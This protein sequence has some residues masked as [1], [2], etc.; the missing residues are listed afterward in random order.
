[1]TSSNAVQVAINIVDGIG[2]KGYWEIYYFS[3]TDPSPIFNA[4]VSGGASGVL[5]SRL[6]FLSGSCYINAVRVSAVAPSAKQSLLKKFAPQYQG[7]QG[8]ANSTVEEMDNCLTYFL[9]NSTRTGRRQVHFRGIP[10]T[11]IVGDQRTPAGLA[12]EP[13]IFAWLSALQGL[14]TLIIRNT[15]YSAQSTFGSITQ[16][17]LG[18][19]ISLVLDTPLNVSANALVNITKCRNFP[20]LRGNWLTAGTGGISSTS[21]PILATGR[22]S[23]PPATGGLVRVV[24]PTAATGY[25]IITVA[26]FNGASVRKTG[27]QPFLPRGRRSAVL[28]HR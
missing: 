28:H 4:L 9:Y 17:A 10:R 13:L 14:G 11:W 7:G 25:W 27:R 15:D 5:S 23:V 12:A 21:L 24:D 3:A 26:D 2:Q 6:A 8:G 22:F 19:N 18:S 20:L 1:M 16:A